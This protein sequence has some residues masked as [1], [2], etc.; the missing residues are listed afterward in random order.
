MALPYLQFVQEMASHFITLT[1]YNSKLTLM[2]SI[3]RLQVFRFK[4]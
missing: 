3:L 1:K 2:D 4:I